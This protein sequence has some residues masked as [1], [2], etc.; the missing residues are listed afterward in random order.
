LRENNIFGDTEEDGGDTEED[1]GFKRKKSFE[2][3]VSLLKQLND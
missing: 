2:Y 3:H 1:G